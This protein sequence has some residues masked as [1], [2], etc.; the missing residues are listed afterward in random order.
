MTVR[1]PGG[2]LRTAPFGHLVRRGPRP[3][4]LAVALALAVAVL[5]F[6]VRWY[7]GR[8][9]IDLE[10]YRDA[11]RA[12]RHGDSPYDFVNHN[13][14][15]Y[16]YTPFAA[17]LLAPLCLVSLVVA[18]PLW[19]VVS[20][21]GLQAAIWV[22]L[23]ALDVRD[24]GRRATL[25]LLGTLGA[26][27]LLPILHTLELGQINILLMLLLLADL[28]GTWRAAGLADAR[29]SR[30]LGVGTGIAAGIKLTPLIFIPYLILTGRVRAAVVATVSFLATIAI[31][32]VFLPSASMSYWSGGFADSGRLSPPLTEIYNQSLRGAMVRAELEGVRGWPWLLPVLLVVTGVVGMTVAVRASRAGN[33]VTGVVACAFTGLYLSPISWHTHWVWCVPLLMLLVRD[34]LRGNR[35]ALVAAVAGWLVFVASG[36]WVVI[37][38]LGKLPQVNFLSLPMLLV[39]NLYLLAAPWLL[40][41]AATARHPG[42]LRGVD[43]GR[44]TRNHR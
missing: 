25:T 15:M 12:V 41:A 43:P 36:C 23:G 29:G 30:W 37:E 40:L 24:P 44:S 1:V 17:L 10:V 34:A 38:L 20:M 13:G 39:G 19:T 26:L 7:S 14:L 22:V 42:A 35:A 9:W 21:L 6:A 11:G 2:G 5:A 27:P 18:V 16:N 8:F 28:L 33:E 4:T 31:G 3:R 32:L